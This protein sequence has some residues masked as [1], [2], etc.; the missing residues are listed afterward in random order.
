MNKMSCE[1]K[2]VSQRPVCLGSL[3]QQD[4][5]ASLAGP[6]LE[7]GTYSVI[8]GRTLVLH[9]LSDWEPLLWRGTFPPDQ[10]GS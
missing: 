5:L 3:L 8:A 4:L 6:T 2:L 7:V 10:H 1:S 9:P